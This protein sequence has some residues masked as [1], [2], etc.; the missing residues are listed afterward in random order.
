MSIKELT[1]N[2]DAPLSEWPIFYKEG[3]PFIYD[4][5]ELLFDKDG[6]ILGN[7]TRHSRLVLYL[8]SLLEVLYKGYFCTLTSELTFRHYIEVTNGL[9]AGQRRYLD[10]TPDLTLIRG[11]D[12]PDT[13]TYVVNRDGPAPSVVFEI[14]SA[15]TYKE[16][17]GR[18]F[19]LYGEAILAKEYFIYDSSRKKFWPGSRLKTWRLVDGKYV[20]I[21]RNEAG[22][23]WSEELESWL[24]E[25]ER[26]LR[27]FDKAGK[28]R[29][30]FEELTEQIQARLEEEQEKTAQAQSQLEQERHKA[31][32]QIEQERHKAQSQIEQERRKTAQAENQVKEERHKAQSQI[33]QER[34]RTTHIQAALEQE[35]QKAERLAQRLRE[36]DPDAEI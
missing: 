22:W 18:K 31:Q 4:D 16:D 26:Y 27:L 30:T 6:N 12:W 23:V 3:L 15:S 11:I 28:Q 19:R 7:H 33:E 9:Q 34:D 32:S 1:I 17:L 36:L 10:I 5:E 8:Y 25:D 35:R 24:V 14:A 21:A 13:A 29:L 2:L 20:E